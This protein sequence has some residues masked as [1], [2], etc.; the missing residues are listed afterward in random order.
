MEKTV[1]AVGSVERN[2]TQATQVW[3]SH[4]P[5]STCATQPL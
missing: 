1:G 4:L 2:G 5:H 3:E